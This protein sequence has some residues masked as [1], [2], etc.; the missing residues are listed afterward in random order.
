MGDWGVGGDDP[1]AKSRMGSVRT[2]AERETAWDL[3]LRK[4]SPAVVR[5]MAG[6]AGTEITGWWLWN[7]RLTE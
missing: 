2:T 6:S 4:F 1:S 5:R 3:S 7:T